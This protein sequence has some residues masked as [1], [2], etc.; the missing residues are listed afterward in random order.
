MGH[1]GQEYNVTFTRHMHISPFLYETTHSLEGSCLYNWISPSIVRVIIMA[2]IMME[3]TIT[4]WAQ[5]HADSLPLPSYWIEQT[6]C[7]YVF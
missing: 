5:I 1:I 3:I 6:T 2:I 4:D 7:Q